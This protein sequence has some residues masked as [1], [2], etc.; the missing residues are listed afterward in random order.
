[1]EINI[2]LLISAHFYLS[3]RYQSIQS[4][5]RYVKT[6]VISANTDIRANILCIPNTFYICFNWIALQKYKILVSICG[7]KFFLE[8]LK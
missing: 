2:I 8:H 4:I 1:M 3:E 6:W 7:K 5:N